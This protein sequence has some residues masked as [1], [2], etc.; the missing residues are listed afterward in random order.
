MAADARS[1]PK[2]IRAYLD[3]VETDLEAFAALFAKKNRLAVYHLQQAA[4]KLVRAVR[5]HRGL[6]NTKDHELAIL[7]DGRKGTDKLPQPLPA[8][9][10][11]RPRILKLEWLSA[12]ATTFRYPTDGGRRSPGPSDDVLTDAHRQLNELLV[13]AR[14]EL[15]GE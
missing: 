1:D 5:L 8:Q 15:L 11:W 12:Y 9:D 13:L 2:V 6:I 14:T 7:V 3:D 10:A 4:E